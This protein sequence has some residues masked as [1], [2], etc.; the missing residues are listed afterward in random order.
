MEP[1]S[2]GPKTQSETTKQAF[3]ATGNHGHH[4]WNG[5]LYLLRS[6]ERL[7]TIMSYCHPIRLL[8]DDLD[9]KA[10]DIMHLAQGH[11]LSYLWSSAHPG[12]ASWQRTE[13]LAYTEDV[14][15][16]AASTA[17]SNRQLF[18]RRRQAVAQTV[19]KGMGATALALR[20]HNHFRSAHL[21]AEESLV[22]KIG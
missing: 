20:L 17:I 8:E 14:L 13:I 6:L 1:V 10:T 22:C 2:A 5:V 7:A 19:K 4:G 21:C 9:S 18:V 15:R 16:W 11:D 3:F 12:L